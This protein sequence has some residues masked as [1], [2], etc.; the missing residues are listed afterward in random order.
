MAT[1]SSPDDAA[2][3]IHR[4]L[5]VA[6]P[7]NEHGNKTILHLA[8]LLKVSKATIWRWIELERIPPDRAK[9]VVD[10]SEG[11]VSL[12]DFHRFVYP[13]YPTQGLS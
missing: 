12:D 13:E 5:L 3:E 2:K 7:V 1:Y 9:K 11:R 8:K 10:L 6:V 4:L